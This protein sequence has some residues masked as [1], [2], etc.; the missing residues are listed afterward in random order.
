MEDKN[1][2]AEFKE[3]RGQEIERMID[4]DMKALIIKIGVMLEGR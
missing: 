2:G 3:M 1:I 4:V